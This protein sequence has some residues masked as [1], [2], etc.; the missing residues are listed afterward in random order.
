MIQVIAPRSNPGA[1]AATNFYSLKRLDCDLGHASSH[2]NARISGHAGGTPMG[3]LSR[4]NSGRGWS[5]ISSIYDT[6]HLALWSLLIAFVIFFC[7]FTLPRLPQLRAH[8]QAERILRLQAENDA[9]CKK[10]GFALGTQKHEAC[11]LDL[12]E[13]RAEIDQRAS[14]DV[15]P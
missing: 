12:Q 15:F 5:L 8:M 9:Y 11:I 14:D 4:K 6:V 13:L 2:A 3:Q 1:I 7:V 10:W